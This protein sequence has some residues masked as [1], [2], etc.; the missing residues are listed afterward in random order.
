MQVAVKAFSKADEAIAMLPFAYPDEMSMRF[1]RGPA[2][3]R[4]QK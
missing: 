3:A 2:T 4:K 1:R